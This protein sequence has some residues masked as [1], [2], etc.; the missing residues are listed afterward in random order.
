MCYL[1]YLYYNYCSNIVCKIIFPMFIFVLIKLHG[2][3]PNI[4]LIVLHWPIKWCEEL[5]TKSKLWISV[6]MVKPIIGLSHKRL[7][8]SGFTAGKRLFLGVAIL[9]VSFFHAKFVTVVCASVD[10]TIF[11]YLF[12]CIGFHTSSFVLCLLILSLFTLFFTL[13]IILLWIYFLIQRL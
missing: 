2:N 6:K 7:C 8:Y 10:F 5:F 4:T 9:L 1:W 12:H 13:W 11:L 3:Y